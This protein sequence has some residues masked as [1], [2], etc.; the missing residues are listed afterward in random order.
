MRKGPFVLAFALVASVLCRARAQPKPEAPSASA[1]PAP[2]LTLTVTP[3]KGGAPWTMK[4]ENAGGVP[5]RLA[6][7]PRL[8][9]LE[10]APPADPHAK[11]GAKA[12]Q[13]VTCRLPDD[14][15]P[16]SDEGH[17]LVVPGKRAWSAAFDPFFYCF[18]ARERAALVS[19]ATAKARFGWPVKPAKNAK[20]QTVS[21]PFVAAPVGAAIGQ[22]A[23]A[24]EIES[25]SF[26]LSESV[27][28]APPASTSTPVAPA[29]S[30]SASPSSSS[31]SS[32]ASP[33]PKP[34]A[35][36]E[37][38]SPLGLGITETMDAARGVDLSATVTLTNQSD[39]SVTLLHRSETV[40]FT[41]SGPAGTV[42]CGFPRI[43]G[44]PIRELFTT[45]APK[46]KSQL[47]V[48]VN[49]ICPPDTF[50]EPGI[51]R[52]LPRIDTRN[53][54]GRRIG[55]KTWDGAASGTTPMLLR[56][57]NPRKPNA[58]ATKRPALD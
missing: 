10:L 49:A 25:A 55:L 29:S 42:S 4:V 51:Y 22:V 32:S 37:A 26:T 34:P 8:L 3:G 41:V 12:P 6:A 20:A 44:S 33:P 45:L 48:L 40:L 43:V 39:R 38:P 30:S 17:E 19:G 52:V 11:K 50:D 13:P 28:I 27:T 18:S 35:D 7:D 36:D 1:L 56:V 57:R 53:A 21:P 47:T 46:G 14:V 9:V 23:A 5:V 2:S 54:S 58:T 24:K 31:S 16:G 15:R